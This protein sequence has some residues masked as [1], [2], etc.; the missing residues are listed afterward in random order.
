MEKNIRT[1]NSTTI[2]D[3]LT[4]EDCIKKAIEAT[5]ELYILPTYSAMLEA[6][7]I[8]KGKKIL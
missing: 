7:K 1:V 8:I 5:N 4:V 3:R 6:R 2:K